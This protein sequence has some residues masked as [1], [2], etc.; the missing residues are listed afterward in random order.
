VVLRS[1]LRRFVIDKTL[2]FGSNLWMCNLMEAGAGLVTDAE[3]CFEPSVFHGG[4][5]IESSL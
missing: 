4:H 3:V 1:G 2:L 5:A